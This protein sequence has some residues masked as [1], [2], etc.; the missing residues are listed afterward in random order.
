MKRSELC[1]VL[2]IPYYF[3]DYLRLC[4]R[5]SLLRTHNHPKNSN[6]CSTKKTCGLIPY[7][8]DEQIGDFGT[9]RWTQNTERSTGLATYT[10]NPGPSTHISFAWTAP[11]VRNVWSHRVYGTTTRVTGLISKQA[12]RLKTF[13]TTFR[14]RWL[15]GCAPSEVAG[16]HGGRS[17]QCCV[18]H[19]PEMGKMGYVACFLLTKFRTYARRASRCWRSRRPPR[20]ATSTASG[21]WRG[22][23]CRGKHRGQIKPRLVTSTSVSSFMET[24]PRFPRMPP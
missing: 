7:S 10:T 4:G 21:W 5:A 24:V 19:V 22:R 17:R 6:S 1:P 23:C 13:G 12:S 20:Q 11:E 15:A 8:T 18:E 14:V 2:Y 9:S 3:N 16:V